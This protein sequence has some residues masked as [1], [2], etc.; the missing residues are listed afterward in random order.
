ME[1]TLLALDLERLIALRHRDPH[2]ILGPHPG[3][4]G[5]IIRAYRPDAEQVSVIP[6]GGKAIAMRRREGTDLF[7]VLVEGDQR[8]FR[9]RLEILLRDGARISIHDPYSFL[10]TLSDMDLYLL[11][12]QTLEHPYEKLGANVR[13][14][15]GV[16]GVAFAVWAPNAE[17][18]SVVGDFNGWDGR[19]HMMRSLGSSGIWEL[20]IPELDSGARYK[21]E[22]RAPGGGF[23]LKGDPFAKATEPPPATASVVYQPHYAFNDVQWLAARR[24]RDSLRLPLSIYEVHLGSWRRVPEEHN[25]SLTYREMAPLLA[26]YVDP[27]GIYPRRTAA[28]HGASFHRIMGLSGDRIFR[29]H[30]ALWLAGRLS[31]PGRLSPSTGH[32][33]HPGLGAGAFPQGRV[34]FG[35]L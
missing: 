22:V 13:E 18:L 27:D 17:G 20:F 1:R 34:Q 11:G 28:R 7:E 12:E 15:E 6:D 29:T 16:Q 25:R 35:P 21:Y 3:S 9:Y 10:P 4:R 32:R 14:L 23:H 26:D 5:T 2:T 19:I 33:S 8:V 30:R 24:S 31:F